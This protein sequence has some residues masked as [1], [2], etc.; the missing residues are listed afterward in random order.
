VAEVP[1]PAGPGRHPGLR[2]APALILGVLAALA[3]GE[4]PE[5]VSGAA[6]A[7]PS[8][9]LVSGEAFVQERSTVTY[10]VERPETL[11]AIL[12]RHHLRLSADSVARLNPDVPKRDLEGVLPPGTRL[13]L[14]IQ[15]EGER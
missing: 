12:R 9:E 15:A 10:T 14:F 4:D 1:R 6:A 2:L 3:G 11:A 8:P 13:V 5:A 7:R